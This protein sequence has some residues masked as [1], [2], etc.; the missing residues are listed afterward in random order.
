MQRARPKP[1]LAKVGI[2]ASCTCCLQDAAMKVTVRWAGARTA[3]K[4]GITM[5]RI[6]TF[7]GLNAESVTGIRIASE[8]LHEVDSCSPRAHLAGWL[9]LSPSA[10]C[11]CTSILEFRGGAG[12]DPDLRDRKSTRLNSSLSSISYAVF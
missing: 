6:F 12:S 3:S 10:D 8:H 4:S 1:L 2:A 7:P 5:L 9:S 11:P